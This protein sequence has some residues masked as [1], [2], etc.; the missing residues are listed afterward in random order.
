MIA[1]LKAGVTPYPSHADIPRFI[2]DGQILPKEFR[3]KKLIVEILDVIDIHEPSI[4][5]SRGLPERADFGTFPGRRAP[6]KV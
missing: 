1:P 5:D 6:R 4:K 3:I 2:S